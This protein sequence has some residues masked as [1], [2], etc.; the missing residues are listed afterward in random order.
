MFALRSNYVRNA[1]RLIKFNSNFCARS[2][3]FDQPRRT[4]IDS[5][6]RLKNTNSV[7]YN[8]TPLRYYS[9]KSEKKCPKTISEA[10]REVAGSAI[11]EIRINLQLSYTCKV[12]DTRNTKTISKIAYSQGVVIVRCDKCSNNH[13]IADNLNWFTD[14]NGK[15]NIEEILAEKGEKVQRSSSGEYLESKKKKSDQKSKENKKS[16]EEVKDKEK[17]PEKNENVDDKNKKEE[18]VKL[19]ADFSRK[20]QNI[21]EK[22]GEI[23][24]SKRDKNK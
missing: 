17:K 15:R 1:F 18:S 12:C 24:S 2:I 10:S 5:V 11:G 8:D 23:L 7:R 13:L 9:E 16:T 4:Y 14:L 20:A 22:I 3:V 19:L 21:K 6:N